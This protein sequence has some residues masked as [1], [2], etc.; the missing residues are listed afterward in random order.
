MAEKGFR[1]P[2]DGLVRAVMALPADVDTETDETAD[3]QR[4]VELRAAENGDG[5]PTLYGYFARFNE[6]TEINS[7][8]EGHFMERVAKGAFTKTFQERTPKVLFQHGMDPQIADKP[9]GAPTTLEEKARG[10]YYEVPLLD[11]SYNR[12]LEPGLRAGLYGASFR[13]RVI[14]EDINE[15][16]ARSDY[17]PDGLPERTIREAQVQE[18][19][20]V[21]FPA[22]EG[23]S[24]GVRSLTD[25]F[26][27]AR[28]ASDSGRLQK[29]LTFVE[30]LDQAPDDE[31]REERDEQHHDADTPAPSTTPGPR[32]TSRRGSRWL[33]PQEPNTERR[34]L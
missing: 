34:W 31:S 21:T 26:I 6:W 17:N 24:A 23:A 22:Y 14:R 7:V 27:A 4:A 19:G 2:R 25:E 29:L 5:R 20:P 1:P 10:A 33:T 13:F 11:T 12:D 32:P 18:F 16:P 3:E 28:F 8:F 30:R 15:E 9:L